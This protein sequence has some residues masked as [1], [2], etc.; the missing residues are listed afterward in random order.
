M[1]ALAL[2]SGG[3]DSTLAARLVQAQGIDV[4]AVNFVSPFCLCGRG[5]CG[6]AGM[7]K[8]LQ[9]PLKTISLG[10]EYLKI[11]R[12]PKHGYG[13]NMNPCIDCRILM[14]KKAKKYAKEIGASFLFTGEVL[15]E[16]PMS[17]H[18]RA[19]DIIE[20]EAGLE[21]MI[22]RP[23]SAELLPMT[24]VEKK[25]W[26]DSEKLLGIRG[27]SRKKQIELIKQFNIKDYPCPAGG[28]LLTYKDYA[29]KIR[30]MFEHK[31]RIRI[32]DV[33]LLKIGRHFR[34]EENRV[35]VGRNK[36]ENERLRDLK[37]LNDYYFEVPDCG[38]PLTILQ[39]P[40]EEK[41]IEI[42]AALTARYS[43]SKEKRIMVGFGQQ[44]LDKSIR[45]PNLSNEEIE[46]L[47]I[48]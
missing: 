22:V 28:C 44:E 23:L 39:G 29:A 2:L 33:L 46:K 6:A 47:R 34:F 10:G 38:S 14:F 41:A 42:A 25:G 37:D 20:K 16:R 13:K 43:D 36:T 15:D 48:K 5:G 9:I 30:D 17:Q 8:Q 32:K 19:L 31:K 40:K 35:I 27:R 24:K 3:L 11:V 18:R 12:K 7:A 21:G 1:K 26:I 4:A 45:A